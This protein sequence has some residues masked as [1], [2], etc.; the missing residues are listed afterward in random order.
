MDACRL[1][2]FA[3]ADFVGDKA[4]SKSTSGGVL[5]LAGPSTWAPLVAICKAQGVVSHSTTEAEVISF[6]VG[7]RTEGLPALIFWD[8]VRPFLSCAGGPA[9]KEMSTSSS[10]QLTAMGG[11]HTSSENFTVHEGSG[12]T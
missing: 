3:D 2:L 10:T 4:N 7:L 6:E 8:F 12:R 9:Q 5:V 1:L 11:A